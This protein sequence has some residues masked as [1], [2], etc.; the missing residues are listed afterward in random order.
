MNDNIR[1]VEDE[2]GLD[3]RECSELPSGSN[4][5][6]RLKTRTETFVIKISRVERPVPISLLQDLAA[7]GFPVAVPRPS[8]DGRR[9]VELADGFGVLFS[10][11]EGEHF[12]GSKSWIR[13]AG[14]TL[15]EFHEI[16]PRTEIAGPEPLV[17]LQEWR[18]R[19]DTALSSTEK[20]PFSHSEIRTF[21]E[22][23]EQAAERLGPD[24]YRPED[25]IVVH[26]DYH[27]DNVLFDK[28]GVA[29][30]LDWENAERGVCHRD[31]S[32][33]LNSFGVAPN[34]GHA[35][36]P[37]RAAL[38]LQSYRETR[39]FPLSPREIHASLVAEALSSVIWGLERTDGDDFYWQIAA[40]FGEK[41]LSL[42]QSRQELVAAFGATS[43]ED[44][45]VG[46]LP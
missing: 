30:V 7:E 25:H 26:G 27:G 32:K 28:D 22:A 3:I 13:A 9:V 35:L 40:G 6:Y 2:Y 4:D 1:A 39:S 24:S 18:S 45:R 15:A 29:A 12:D 10:Y 5:L 38:F 43:S 11:C 41:L 42:K 20:T 8:V 37:S 34:K 17:L 44:A 21:R 46:D 19:L 36:S 31:V 16:S 23:A 33:G 14:R